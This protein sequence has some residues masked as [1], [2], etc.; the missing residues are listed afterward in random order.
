MP[1]PASRG[2][3]PPR[4]QPSRIPKVGGQRHVS[5]GRARQGHRE[6]DAGVLIARQQRALR[7][8]IGEAVGDGGPEIAGRARDHHHSVGQSIAHGH[9]YVSSPATRSISRPSWYVPST[10][11]S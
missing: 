5:P 7:A 6:P 11:R 1:D 9:P 2:L 8:L 3:A 4:P 10:P